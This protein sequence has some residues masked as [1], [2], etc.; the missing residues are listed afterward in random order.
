MA[1]TLPNHIWTI[2]IQ[3][4]LLEASLSDC[5]RLRQVNS[6]FSEEV[7]CSLFVLQIRDLRK[8]VRYRRVPQSIGV[9]Q[10]QGFFSK[11]KL[12]QKPHKSIRKTI[13][14]ILGHDS[15][16]PNGLDGTC[17]SYKPHQICP[18]KIVG[19]SSNS[20]CKD[21]DMMNAIVSA[22]GPL[23]FTLGSDGNEFDTTATYLKDKRY[24]LSLL[25]SYRG[26]IPQ[27][28]YLSQEIIA[29]E[30]MTGG[31]ADS[32]LCDCFTIATRQNNP[33]LVDVLFEESKE[34]ETVLTSLG[35]QGSVAN[36][37]LEAIRL[38]HCEVFEKLLKWQWKFNHD[39]WN[40]S[41]IVKLVIDEDLFPKK[42]RA[43][44]EKLLRTLFEW[45]DTWRNISEMKDFL[46]KVG[47]NDQQ[48][49]LEIA[50]E[51]LKSQHYFRHERGQEG[52]FSSSQPLTNLAIHGNLQMVKLFLD[53]R[54][55]L[56]PHTEPHQ[57][58]EM[59]RAVLAQE[60]EN[61]T[62]H[63][64]LMKIIMD[65]SG[66]LLESRLELQKLL[67][68]NYHLKLHTWAWLAKKIGLQS[69]CSHLVLHTLGSAMLE[70]AVESLNVEATR[71]LVSYLTPTQFFSVLRTHIN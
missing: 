29:D 22:F 18:S 56:L 42:D 1:G 43:T 26:D 53:N 61:E 10:L 2:I 66:D 25:T 8:I 60:F 16:A 65:Y 31:G 5:L 15:K 71:F 32:I 63:V 21:C 12:T 33:L 13:L 36:C 68:Q 44:H 64:D 27:V 20:L 17:L 40:Y 30:T 24:W 49:Y 54:K 39:S 47:V 59:R 6:W 51:A 57:D 14:R 48:H 34:C 9:L 19:S 69:H 55:I 23:L 52:T 50:V 62:P 38:G 70:K 11:R 37:L 58:M 7:L 28:K 46:V 35:K 67:I 3:Q 45:T 41:R 4:H